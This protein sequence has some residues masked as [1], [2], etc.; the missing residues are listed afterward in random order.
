MCVR[1]A[2]GPHVVSGRKPGPEGAGAYQRRGPPVRDGSPTV[3]V[4][5]HEHGQLVADPGVE[6][7]QLV[8]DPRVEDLQLACD[9]G[10][11]AVVR[12][13]RLTGVP[14]AVDPVL[15]TGE[16][17]PA[18]ARSA[19]GAAG[20]GGAP[21]SSTSSCTVRYQRISHAAATLSGTPHTTRPIQVWP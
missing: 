8:G 3:A 5:G 9:P 21:C 18:V 17:S 13:P 15:V 11:R 20:A 16:V 7:G 14:G 1:P 10:V 4:G 19:A 2:R 6:H 12:S